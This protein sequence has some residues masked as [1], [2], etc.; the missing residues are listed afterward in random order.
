[1]KGLLGGKKNKGGSSVRHTLSILVLNQPGVLMRVAGMF[2]RRGFNIES[3]AVGVTQFPRHSRITAVIEGNQA[4]ISQVLKQVEKL[5]EVKAAKL[6]PQESAI[7]RSM[8]LIKVKVE[9]D[10]RLEVLKL[11]EIFRARVVDV[12]NQ[13]LVIELT[14]DE[15][16]LEA[17]ME[18]LRPYEILEV[19][20]TGAIGL[21]RG[22]ITI[23]E[24]EK[25]CE[26]EKILLADRQTAKGDG[27]IAQ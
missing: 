17:L 14:G 11:T 25:V 10:R 5:V 21:D 1:V 23:Y 24:I 27:R 20:R 13:A 15:S 19:V 12:A 8:A 2:F 7:V 3:L 26:L 6:L 4:V 18:A 9:S 22:G 16:K